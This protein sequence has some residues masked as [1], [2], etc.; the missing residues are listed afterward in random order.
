[1]LWPGTWGCH[2]AS[3]LSWH[4]RLPGAHFKD[5]WDGQRCQHD[6]G[7]LSCLWCVVWVGW[8]SSWLFRTY[9]CALW[10]Y[11][12]TLLPKVEYLQQRIHMGTLMAFF[13][14]KNP[15]CKHSSQGE[16]RRVIWASNFHF[17]IELILNATKSSNQVAG[18][19]VCKQVLSERKRYVLRIF[20]QLLNDSWVG[21]KKKSK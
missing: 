9:F 1:M 15:L 18:R 4:R 6:A 21:K 3:G 16:S 14:N 17:F 20:S 2:Y 10:Y 8:K 7:D 11:T 5:A 19:G 13:F 12:A